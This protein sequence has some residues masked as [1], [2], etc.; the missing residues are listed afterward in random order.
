[1]AGCHRVQDVGDCHVRD[2]VRRRVWLCVY[3]EPVA[4]HIRFIELAVTRV[5]D[6]EVLIARELPAELVE[7]RQDVVARGVVEAVY[8]KPVP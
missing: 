7:S 6:E 3:R 5:V 1:M 4:P 8:E 2:P